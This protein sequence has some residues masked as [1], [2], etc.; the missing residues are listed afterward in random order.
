MAD[1]CRFFPVQRAPTS[2]LD[3]LVVAFVVVAE[4]IGSLCVSQFL[5]DEG[6]AAM[7]RPGDALK[8]KQ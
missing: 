6:T 4:L 8:V 5:D 3:T 7:L 2:A 1:S